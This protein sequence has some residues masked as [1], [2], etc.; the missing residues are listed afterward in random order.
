V[1]SSDDLF[2]WNSRE[3]YF[4]RS[5]MMQIRHFNF[6]RQLYGCFLKIIPL[7][8]PLLADLVFHFFTS[9][10]ASSL[11]LAIF[12]FAV[13]LILFWFGTAI[14][15]RYEF[16]RLLN[17]FQFPWYVNFAFL[18]F[19]WIFGRL[20]MTVLYVYIVRSQKT[21]LSSFSRILTG[22][23]IITVSFPSVGPIFWPALRVHD[24]RSL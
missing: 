14:S 3:T 19:N 18:S 11:Y 2:S 6:V 24:R 5:L 21:S 8:S 13:F 16:L 17:E 15:I 10:I 9:F 23:T 22:Y 4:P 7:P 20:W 1:R 12:R